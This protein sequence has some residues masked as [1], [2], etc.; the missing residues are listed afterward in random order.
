MQSRPAI[1][2]SIFLALALAACSLSPLQNRIEVGEERFVVFV[3]EGRDGRTDIFAGLPAGGELSRITFTPV[4]ESH[5][6][7]TPLG[8]AIA[9]IRHPPPSAMAIPRLV[10]VNLLNGA[11]RTFEGTPLAGGVGGLAWSPDQDGLLLRSGSATWRIAFPFDG[12]DPVRLEG[13][14]RAAADS[15]IDVYLGTPAF[16]RATA[17]DG[18]GVCVVG[19]SGEPTVLSRPGRDPFRWGSDS[20]AW[21][22]DDR[23]MVRPLGPGAA[24][25]ITWQVMPANMRQGSY[26]G[27]DGR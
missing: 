15:L 12:G 24:R 9:F 26:A 18:G 25:T 21:F 1:V 20:V 22:E 13:A 17:C 10:V 6:A 7:L 27:N 11:E 4:E 14:A 3:A 8:D 16:A 5:P 2:P 23:L 19:P